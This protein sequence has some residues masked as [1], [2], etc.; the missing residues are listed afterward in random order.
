[1]NTLTNTT[2]YT[3]QVQITDDIKGDVFASMSREFSS[4][5]E[6][7]LG[8]LDKH[9]LAV[10]Q[11]VKNNPG[12]KDFRI[13]WSPATKKVSISGTQPW[14]QEKI[15]EFEGSMKAEK[16]EIDQ[17]RLL[18]A[19]HPKKAIDAIGYMLQQ[20]EPKETA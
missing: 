18:I 11:A 14:T 20:T 12:C 8:E 13:S 5:V 4:P 1:M 10:R 6:F 7:Y 2:F 9:L 19:K 15:N 16:S 3:D 17:M